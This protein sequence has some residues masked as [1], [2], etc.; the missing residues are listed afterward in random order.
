MN[1]IKPLK[2]VIES[3]ILPTFPWVVD[4]EIIPIKKSHYT[5]V[6]VIYYVD[7]K[8]VERL[9]RVKLMGQT[10]T[11]YDMIGGID[12]WVYNGIIITSIED[13]HLYTYDIISNLK[14]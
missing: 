6:R 12:D 9:T 7:R 13:K 8:H 11:L 3:L 14:T 10:K 2:K 1:I 4:Y 5:A